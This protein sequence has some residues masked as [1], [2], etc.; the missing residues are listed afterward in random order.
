MTERER[1]REREREGAKGCEGAREI[2]RR[3][4]RDRRNEREGGTPQGQSRLLNDFCCL[5]LLP[6]AEIA[7]DS[8]RGPRGARCRRGNSDIPRV[9]R[10]DF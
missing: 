9:A 8:L 2:E 10:G 5:T 1:E 7:A 3:E 6:C 4:R